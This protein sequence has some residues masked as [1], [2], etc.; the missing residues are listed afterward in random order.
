MVTTVTRRRITGRNKTARF[1]VNAALFEELGERLVGKPEIALAELIKNS[2]DADAQNCTLSL[3]K[4][5]ITI[6]DSGHGMTEA[7]FLRN[8]MVVSTQEKGNA[9]YSRI[10]QRGM[11]GSKGVGRFSARFLGHALELTSVAHDT[12]S[13]TN[14]ELKATFDWRAMSREENIETIEVSY[15]VQPAES[16]TKPGTLLRIYDLRNEAK[17]ISLAKVKTDVLRLTDPMA[18]LEKPPFLRL[19]RSDAAKRDPGFSL[20]ITTG[21]KD[22]AGDTATLQSIQSEILSRYIGR[23]RMVVTGNNLHYQVFWRNE[24]DPIEDETIKLSDFSGAFTSQ[25]LEVTDDDKKTDE[26]GLPV[27]VE[28]VPHI[29]VSRGLSSSLFIDLRYFPVRPG[30]FAN[31]GVDGRVAQAWLKDA[32]SFA[33]VDNNFSMAAYADRESDWL[34]LNENNARNERNWQSIFTTKLYPMNPIDK[35]DP[36]RNPMLALPYMTNLLGRLHVSTSKP[37]ADADD[38]II[39]T[40]L[41]PNMDRESLRENDAFRL[42][43]HI[44]RFATELLAHFDRKIRLQEEERRNR[45]KAREAKTE[46]TKAIAEIR[47]SD[48]IVPEFRRK[49]VDQLEAAQTRLAEAHDYDKEARMSLELMSMMGIMAGFMTHEF[50]KAMH[51]LKGAAAQIRALAKQDPKLQRAA[52]SISKTENAIAHYMD[53]M[54]LFVNRAR[55]PQP[56]QFK[57]NAQVTLVADTLQVTAK[58]HDIDI[59]I[60]IDSRLA[61]PHM[62]LAAY[63]GIVVNL[64]SNAM[65]ALI[66]KVSGDQRR[67]RIFATNDSNKHVLVCADNGIGIADY[68][69]PR[70]WDP[71]FTTTAQDNNPLGS[72]LGLGLSV[73]QNVV[74]QLRGRIELLD[75][76]PPGFTTAFRVTLP[77]QTTQ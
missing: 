12:A 2:Y 9:R 41:Q 3:S 62:P 59:E 55:Q 45:Q 33:I 40:W 53:Y 5:E 1:K 25:S 19:K 60:D 49:I 68:L 38:E 72:G 31:T 30:T 15:S 75:T 52:E 44:A 46:L 24:E 71:L 22:D 17:R 73:V 58:D 8:W 67:I 26:R 37:P 10:F 28:M 43:W 6:S 13:K 11:A 36:A 7:E 64:L 48:D 70:I 69:K 16:G 35:V 18:G 54:R 47:V 21:V 34:T 14:T 56:Q 27:A 63:H 61:G 77:L 32:S 50:E 20:T 76:A 4:R 39:Q 57:A 42:L 66:P 65:K 23:V 74:K 29:P 51:S